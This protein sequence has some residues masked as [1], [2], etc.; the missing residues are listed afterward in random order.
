MAGT[1]QGDMRM[2]P[3]IADR[4]DA[5]RKVMEAFEDL[6]LQQ[7]SQALQ[8]ERYDKPG[9]S[10]PPIN[11]LGSPIE[12]HQRREAEELFDSQQYVASLQ[13]FETLVTDTW[14]QFN[15]GVLRDIIN[16]NDGAIEQYELAVMRDKYNGIAHFQLGVARFHKG[17]YERALYHFT[18]AQTAIR[19]VEESDAESIDYR[20]LGLNFKLL[21][22]DVL[23]NKGVCHRFLE[24]T[25]FC[26]TSWELAKASTPSLKGS[27]K[28]VSIDEALKN[29]DELRFPIS[30]VN[31]GEVSDIFRMRLKDK[32]I[33]KR[34]YL[35]NPK[36]VR[37]KPNSDGHQ[38]TRSEQGTLRTDTT[39]S[40]SAGE[41][42]LS[43]TTAQSLAST[44][45]SPS[46][47]S[48]LQSFKDPTWTTALTNRSPILDD[49]LRT[50]IDQSVPV[51]A[52]DSGSRPRPSIG[53]RSF[54]QTREK[55]PDQLELGNAAF[56]R[57]VPKEHLRRT[58]RRA[59]SEPPVDR[60]PV[61]ERLKNRAHADKVRDDRQLGAV[62]EDEMPQPSK[63]LN[64]HHRI[65]QPSDRPPQARS[66]S[67]SR[68]Q[69]HPPRVSSNRVPSFGDRTRLEEV[70]EDEAPLRVAVS[71]SKDRTSN[72]SGYESKAAAQRIASRTELE[73]DTLRVKV[74]FGQ[75]TETLTLKPSI[76]LV[77]FVV[78]VKKTFGID[79]D[80]RVRR[81]DAEANFV[82]FATRTDWD[83][84]VAGYRRAAKQRGDT[85]AKMKIWVEER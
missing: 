40:V 60:H 85:T 47:A 44:G 34:N 53:G 41:S 1:L 84:I 51:E 22:C 15:C 69:V 20:E 7:E 32:T 5:I 82:A 73:V 13:S 45:P 21:L 68:M 36:L 19:R 9:P 27:P 52:R 28:H 57:N 56:E 6:V 48:S 16:D 79:R 26:Q 10:D 63:L 65:H 55:R 29:V 25:P 75:A 58:P 78:I 12:K 24:K 77:E 17:Q 54:S 8:K 46:S 70:L 74:Q 71:D 11:N 39:Q 4:P 59:E 49:T 14:L 50:R 64:T 23:F 18:R 81:K 67:L 62:E 72:Q 31:E 2:V 30:F 43:K 66:Q 35:G 76:S 37:S 83:L 61:P 42:P 33:A 3:P 38:R 80:I